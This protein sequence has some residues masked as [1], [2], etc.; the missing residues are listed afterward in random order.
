MPNLGDYLGMLLSEI[1]VA[2]MH[3]DLEAVR[4]AE[5]YASHP[6]LRHMPVPRFRL[7]DVQMDIPVA[8]QEMEEPL[9]GAPPRG[10][11][12][13]GEMR[14]TF[15]TALATWTKEERIRPSAQVKGK[16][17]LALDDK[18]A[19]IARS[20]E[21]TANVRGVADELSAVVLA[22]LTEVG[23]PLAKREPADVNTLVARL[24]TAARAEF[25]RLHKP[26]PRL[27]VLV[28][29]AEIREAGPSEI[30]TRLRLK[31]IE[32]AVEWTTIESD[33]DRKDRLIAE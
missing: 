28:T 27:S 26:P 9:P 14:K 22:T 12:T 23:G 25:V 24:S 6:L 33:G 3:A 21:I 11:P 29:T 1:T 19:E 16:L 10:A 13:M 31:I 4:V 15:D 7:P 8:I 5:Q 18:E 20:A 17:K 32:E 30:V 2:R